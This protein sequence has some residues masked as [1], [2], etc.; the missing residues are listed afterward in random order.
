MLSAVP[1]RA[2]WQLLGT[3]VLDPASAYKFELYDVRHDWTQYSDVAAQN[4]KKVAELTKLM[5]AEFASHQVLPLDASVATR[6]VVPRPSLIAGRKLFDYSGEPTTGFPTSTAPNLLNTSYTIT[7]D[8]EVPE[9]GG[10]GVIVTQGG[11]F[12]GYGLYLLKGK[13]T[14][15]WNLLDLKRVKWQ[16]PEALSAGKHKLV[17]DFKYDG[18]GFATLA[19]NNITGIGRPG[20]GTFSVDGKVV[21]TEKLERTIPLVLPWDETFDIGS[22]TGTPVDDQDYQIPF[23]FNGKIDKLTIALDPPK[24]TPEDL[25][26]LE[27]G[28]RAAADAN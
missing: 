7:A 11:R 8:I 25:K 13:P 23:A 14:F 2:P 17:Y 20:T 22:D 21:A 10:E 18:L 27:D 24:L 12:G 28:A 26:K 4:P 1:L 9:G 5:F 19:F 16:A 15:T 3:A 6:L